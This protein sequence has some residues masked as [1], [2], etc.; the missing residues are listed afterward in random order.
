MKT[1]A[2]ALAASALVLIVSEVPAQLPLD[3]SSY[4]QRDG[5]WYQRDAVGHEWRIC[6]GRMV[7]R[8]GG[9]VS[10]EV[11]SVALARQGLALTNPKLLPGGVCLCTYDPDISPP[12]AL[13]AIRSES[14]IAGAWVDTYVE[15]FGDPYYSYQWGLRRARVDKAWA[16]TTGSDSV[17]VAVLDRGF[18]LGHEDLADA[19]WTHTA[20]ANGTLNVDDDGNGYVDDLHG[21]DFISG[22]NDPS[23]AAG[24]DEHGTAVAGV[25]CAI[26]NNGLGVAGVA[27]GDDGGGAW[28]VPVRVHPATN[29]AAAID[30]AW[31]LGVDIINMSFGTGDPGGTIAAAIDSA[32]A[33]GVLLFAATGNIGFEYAEFP[34]SEPA[35]IAVGSADPDDERI[36]TSNYGSH[37]DIVAPSASPLICPDSLVWTTDNYSISYSY[38]PGYSGCGNC[39]AI[40]SDNGRYFG[41]FGGTS[42]ACPFAVGIAALIRAHYPALS[43]AEI[44][45]RLLA[46]AIDLGDP[47][48]DVEYGNGRVDA[49][50]AVTEW[51]TITGNVTWSP[52]D[53]HDGARYVSGDL[54]IAEGATLTIM[55]GTIV[56]I[57]SED[58]LGAG[59]DEDL[60]EIN[61]EGTLVADGTA[62]DPIIFESWAQESNEDWVGFYFDSGSGGGTF[63]HCEISGA[64][65]AIESY[66]PLTVTNTEINTCRYAA[67]VVQDGGAL[68]QNCGLINPGSFGIFLTSDATVIRNTVVDGAVSIGLYV[69]PNASLVSRNTGYSSCE[70]GLYVNGTTANV[71][72]SCGF[73][74]NNIGVHFYNTG[75]YPVVRNGLFENNADV[76]V[77]CDNSASPL[78]E[79]NYIVDG[80]DGI[81]C[82]NSASPTIKQNLIK[83]VANGVTTASSANPDIGHYSSTGFNSIAHT[84]GKYVKN[85]NSSGTIYAQNNCWNVDTGACAPSSSKF[86]GSVDRSSPICCDIPR[87]DFV[88][89]LPHPEAKRSATG[90]VAVVPNPFNPTTTIQYSLAAPGK[91]E[92]NIYDVAGRLVD[93]LASGTQTAGLHAAVWNGTDRRGSPVASG[94]YF[95]R[96]AAAGEVFT[97][98]M[99]L[100]K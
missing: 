53:T 94:V 24:G 25:A 2:S 29:V 18:E 84:V 14:A 100:L 49:Y 55:P 70:I 39:S 83:R 46:S 78:I 13:V 51:G 33:H 42:A 79:G 41:A 77:L 90:L 4:E 91:V 35:V 44:R 43:A 22:D 6:P 98:K 82:S 89:H 68:I 61:V 86:Q 12:S 57:A 65:Y 95:V 3:D 69:Q 88:F 81:Y 73:S 28:L 38:N 27:G 20:E 26:R 36:C 17:V 74:Y 52:S 34:A 45:E 21:W 9:G 8:F 64:E 11:K 92:I 7:V 80:G 67:I 54:T 72:S 99:V 62:A 48:F 58:D 50:R 37:L 87:D 63:D 66:V 16:V 30:Y 97:R 96:M 93:V 47:G 71:D 56:R 23:P 32:D 75:S 1:F 59:A 19:I 5:V 76:A 10:D 85:L 31:R 40:P 60:I 15:F